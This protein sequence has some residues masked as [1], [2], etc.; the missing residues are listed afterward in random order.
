MWLF[1]KKVYEASGTVYVQLRGRGLLG[2]PEE[3]RAG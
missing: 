1:K 3:W 2:L